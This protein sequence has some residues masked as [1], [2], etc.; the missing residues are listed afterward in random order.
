LLL[1][2]KKKKKQKSSPLLLWNDITAQRSVKAS[3]EDSCGQTRDVVSFR[4]NSVLS[5]T[6]GTTGILIWKLSSV[7]CMRC[8]K[9][10]HNGSSI[11]PFS[12][13]ISKTT[14]WISVQLGYGLDDRGSRI[15][16]PA[17]SAN[18]SLHHRVKT[19]SGAHPVS[20][21]MGTGC[22]IPEGKAAGE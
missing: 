6:T 9:L 18:F 12:R 3:G 16:F 1:K 11:C 15:R 14:Q 20:Y 7:L 19:G 22:P 5:A 21:P 17:G 13:F 2:K 4:L 8:I 10:M